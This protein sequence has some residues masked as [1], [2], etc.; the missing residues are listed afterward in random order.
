MRPPALLAG[1]I[2]R[3]RSVTDTFGVNL[4]TPNPM[5]VDR[6]TFRDYAGKIQADADAY[7]LDL[8]KAEPVEDDDEFHAKIRG[9]L[10]AREI[11]GVEHARLFAR[12]RAAASPYGHYEASAGSRRIPVIAFTPA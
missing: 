6:N 5:P 4:F 2:A 9:R 10:V 7:G 3:V 11:T 8:S 12:V 1:D